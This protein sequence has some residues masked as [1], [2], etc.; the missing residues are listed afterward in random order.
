MQC[1]GHRPICV[2][3]TNRGL[4]CKYSTR[5]T[6]IRSSMKLLSS[7]PSDH[8]RPMHQDYV[9]GYHLEYGHPTPAHH[10]R[11]GYCQTRAFL[12]PPG[13]CGQSVQKIPVQR[14]SPITD[15]QHLEEDLFSWHQ[16]SALPDLYSDPVPVSFRCDSWTRSVSDASITAEDERMLQRP[17]HV[18]LPPTDR[19]HEITKDHMDQEFSFNYSE[20]AAVCLLFYLLSLTD[21]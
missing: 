5:E 3:C 2:R 21:F 19:Y 6:R 13:D 15:S 17:A 9:D 14:T 12:G 1:S 18:R 10:S 8:G 16:Y 4:V 11:V 20:Y 7:L